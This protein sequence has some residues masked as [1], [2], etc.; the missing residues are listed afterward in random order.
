[1]FFE[2]IVLAI[3]ADLTAIALREIYHLRCLPL[4]VANWDAA[5]ASLTL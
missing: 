1:M 5:S 4:F 3:A 2:R